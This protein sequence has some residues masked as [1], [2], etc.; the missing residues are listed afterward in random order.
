MI[1]QKIQEGINKRGL[2]LMG[3]VVCGYPSFKANLEILACMDEAGIDLVELQFPFSEPIADGP[4]FLMANQ[5][6]LKQGTRVADCFDLLEKVS[7]NFSMTPLMMGY[8]NT[9]YKMGEKVFCQKLASVGGKGLIIP[10]LPA[11][12]EGAHLNQLCIDNKLDLIRLVAPTN[13]KERLQSLVE[14][15][16]GFVYAVARLGVTGK[17]THFSEEI[18]SYIQHLKQVSKVPVAVGFGI[19]K[20]EHLDEL[21]GKVDMAVLGSAILQSYLNGKKEGVQRFFG[22]L[23]G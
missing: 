13:T 11:L 15:A 8:Y 16:H 23:L 12:E 4:L 7:Q 22:E 10:D 3:H 20:K 21:R 6:S 17:E 9:L 1:G 18:L 2:A 14:N 19:S 5:E